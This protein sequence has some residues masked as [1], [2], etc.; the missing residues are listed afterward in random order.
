MMGKGNFTEDFKRDA[1]A[2]IVERGYPI[3]RGLEYGASALAATTAREPSPLRKGSRPAFRTVVPIIGAHS[4]KICL[5]LHATHFGCV[6]TARMKRKPRS[7]P[8]FSICRA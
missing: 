8:A 6:A 1:V 2:Q 5:T 3:P 4:G 7:V